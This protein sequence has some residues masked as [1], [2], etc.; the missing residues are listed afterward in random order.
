M[1]FRYRVTP[2]TKVSVVEP[3]DPPSGTDFM[4]MRSTWLGA[5]VKN[6]FTKLPKSSM[7]ATLWEVILAEC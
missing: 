1:H 5:V 6:N 4:A 3:N 7:A 2:K